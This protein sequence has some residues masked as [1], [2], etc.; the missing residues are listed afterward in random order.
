MRIK[1]DIKNNLVTLNCFKK[2]REEHVIDSAA[3]FT[4]KYDTQHLT[5]AAI[6]PL[7][8][9]KCLFCVA[10][11]FYCSA[12]IVI[13]YSSLKCIKVRKGLFGETSEILFFNLTRLDGVCLSV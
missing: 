10:C 1:V 3:S 13:E 4:V 2:N 7:C 9:H 8:I 12:S 5:K 11:L 6:H